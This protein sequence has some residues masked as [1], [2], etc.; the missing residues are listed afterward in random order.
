MALAIMGMMMN[1]CVSSQMQQ[2]TT[3]NQG[4]GT[5]T[6]SSTG[7][8]NLGTILGGL[9]G[10][11]GIGDIISGTLGITTTEIAGT[12]TYT[13]PAVLFESDNLLTKAGGQLAAQTI[14]KKL[15]TYYQKVGIK[16]GKMTMTFDNNGNFTQTIGSKTQS[17]TYTVNNGQ[18]S[19]TYQGGTKQLVGTTQFS[20]NNL[21]IVMD[22]T[23]LLDYVK[24]AAASINN[25]QLSQISSLA[26]S[27]SG[28]KAGLKF[29]K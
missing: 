8:G 25:S 5:T 1:S 21:V 22:V 26:N 17:G 28:M 19:L 29:T 10:L 11:Q 15:D 20:G 16:P 6:G 14:A 2:G 13:E 18:V 24:T 9:G 23:K 27:V 7:T 12:W 3:Y 4:T